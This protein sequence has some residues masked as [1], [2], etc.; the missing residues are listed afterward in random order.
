M[1]KVREPG[2]VP[3]CCDVC[4]GKAIS[5]AKLASTQDPSASG[6]PVVPVMPQCG[7]PEPRSV[8]SG[9][10]PGHRH[11]QFQVPCNDRNVQQQ[12]HSRGEMSPNPAISPRYES[13]SEGTGHRKSWNSSKQ[14]LRSPKNPRKVHEGPQKKIAKSKRAQWSTEAL[15]LAIEGLD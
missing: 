12:V 1:P 15:H 14:A 8:H 6:P 11:T 13:P 2:P 10:F 5:M 4:K 3:S 9:P 7:E